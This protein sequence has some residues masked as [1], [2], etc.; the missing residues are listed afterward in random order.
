MPCVCSL[1]AASERPIHDILRPASMATIVPTDWRTLEATGAAAREI[2]TLAV[3]EAGLPDEMTVL[4]GVHW[5]RIEK[6]FSVFGEIDFVVVTP[7]ARVL[8]IEQKSG[9]LKETPEGLI[10]SYQGKE[11]RVSVQLKRRATM[12]LR[13]RIPQ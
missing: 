6:G 10:K 4:H 7:S 2:E 5:T 13:S 8:L 12:G 3:L 9:F 11:K 1:V